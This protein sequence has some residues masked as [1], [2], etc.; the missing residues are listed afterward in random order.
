MYREIQSYIRN[1]IFWIKINKISVDVKG[2]FCGDGNANPSH[3]RQL[4]GKCKGTT[5]EYKVEEEIK[6]ET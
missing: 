5:D 3:F 1:K 6:T 4:T 2:K